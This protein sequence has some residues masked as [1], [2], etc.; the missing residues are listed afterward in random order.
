[1]VS[2]RSITLEI[3][4][5]ITLVLILLRPTVIIYTIVRFS[6]L[7]EWLHLFIGAVLSLSLGG[8]LPLI[9]LYA[10]ANLDNNSWGTRGIFNKSGRQHQQI[11]S[12]VSGQPFVV[13]NLKWKTAQSSSLITGFC[14]KILFI[15]FFFIINLIFIIVAIDKNNQNISS[16]ICVFIQSFTLIPQLIISSL[17]HSDIHFCVSRHEE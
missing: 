8:I 15:L 17:Y 2:H 13:A 10:F 6:K 1:M 12:P 16:S 9:C 14:K 11:K 5:Y 7:K 3:G 4:S